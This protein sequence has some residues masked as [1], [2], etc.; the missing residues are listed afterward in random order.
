MAAKVK[1][2]YN[3]LKSMRLA[4][5]PLLVNE[6]SVQIC[7][8]PHAP[9]LRPQATLD[10]MDEDYFTLGGSLST[11]YDRVK[12]KTDCNVPIQ[13]AQLLPDS[14]H[15]ACLVEMTNLMK[16]QLRKA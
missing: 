16:T 6:P 1:Q 4:C 12:E 10:D 14:L 8:A 2:N 5:S 9:K 3:Q 11:D 13:S 7:T 15:L